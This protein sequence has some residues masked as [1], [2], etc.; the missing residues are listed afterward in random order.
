MA[1]AD[2]AE[3][4]ERRIAELRD[5]LSGASEREAAGELSVTDQ[6]QA[7][8]ASELEDRERTLGVIEQL[9]RRLHRLRTGED[10]ANL[11]APIPG[12]DA[13]ADD[14]TPLDEPEPREDLSA[15]PMTAGAAPDDPDLVADPQ[16]GAGEPDTDLPGALYPHEGGAPAVGRPAPDDARLEDYRPD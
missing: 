4:L 5:G 13:D 15:I 14:T 3:L 9:E 7:D 1:P 8:A 16:E 10:P 6:H 12:T 2:E 11:R